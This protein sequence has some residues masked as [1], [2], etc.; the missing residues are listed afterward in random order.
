MLCKKIFPVPNFKKKSE[1]RMDTKSK[2][3]NSLK[4]CKIAWLL[5][6]SSNQLLTDKEDEV[7]MASAG[8]SSGGLRTGQ[9]KNI[10]HIK[11][12]FN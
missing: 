12:D 10:C 3:N 1:T 11:T 6:Q 4:Q 2:D 9:L 7:G 8:S 5:S